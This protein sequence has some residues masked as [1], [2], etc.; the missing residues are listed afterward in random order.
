[1]SSNN[2][3]KKDPN[4]VKDYTFDWTLN[5]AEYGDE[6]DTSSFSFGETDSGMTIESTANTTTDATVWLSG[7]NDTYKEW[8]VFNEIVTTGG[9]T[10]VDVIYINVG[11]RR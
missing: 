3:Y 9:R 1:M 8:R 7:G 6:I 10:L 5:L 4:E 11:S 2:H